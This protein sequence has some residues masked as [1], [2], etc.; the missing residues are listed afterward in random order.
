MS[1][2]RNEMLSSVNCCRWSNASS[3]KCSTYAI[4]RTIRLFNPLECVLIQPDSVARLTAVDFQGVQAVQVLEYPGFQCVGCSLVP[5][6]IDKLE[7]IRKV[8]EVPDL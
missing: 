6:H 1:P 4:S 8:V 2:L 7:Q 3:G 5:C